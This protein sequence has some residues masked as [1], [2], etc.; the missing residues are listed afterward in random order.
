VVWKKHQSRPSSVWALAASQHGV[1][2]R[3]QLIDLGMSQRAIEHRLAIGR[4]H[5]IERGVYAVGRPELSRRGKWMTAVLSCGSGAAIS[6]RSAAALWGF[7][8]ERPGRIDVS[9]PFPSPRRRPGIHVHRRPGLSAADVT[10]EDGIALTRP[11]LT[12]IDLAR[13]LEAKTLER[14]I[15]EA[16]RLDVIDP[17]SLLDALDDYVARPGVGRL[18]ELL[19]VQVFRLTDSE[20][21]RR[22][23][24]L[25]RDAKLPLPQT[26]TRL[27]GFKVDFHWPGL[28]LVVETDGLRYHRTPAQQARDR[29]R[30]QAHTA[31]GLTTLRFTHA[32][33]HSDPEL[34]LRTLR[35]VIRRLEGTA[36]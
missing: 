8:R 10:I 19:G 7:G 17:E 11:V 2:A 26:G 12:M 14:A 29:E 16:D 27:N 24:R 3:Q 4:L 32:Q 34:V 15:N 9:V 25:V 18:R 6:H 30:D 31:A 23:L 22:F 33:I 1:V 21:E 35:R 20:L 36:A 5:R 13:H 28:G